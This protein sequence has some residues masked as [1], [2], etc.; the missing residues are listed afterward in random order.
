MTMTMMVNAVQIGYKQSRLELALYTL[1]AFGLP[2]FTALIPFS[3]A[4]HPYKHVPLCYFDLWSGRGLAFV[5]IN[6]YTLSNIPVWCC[7]LGCI[8]L[9]ILTYRRLDATTKAVGV[10]QDLALRMRMQYRRLVY[11]PGEGRFTLNAEREEACCRDGSVAQSDDGTIGGTK[12]VGGGKRRE[13]RR[14]H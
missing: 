14:K 5:F 2:V 9:M 7:I 3:V 13:C 12:G 11:Y 6:M 10:N 1:F 4:A 8:I